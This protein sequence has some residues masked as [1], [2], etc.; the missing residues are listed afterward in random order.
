MGM[1]WEFT[2][3]QLTAYLLVFCRMAGIVLFNPL[4]ARRNIPTQFSM[5]LCMGLALLV[6][7]GMT[8]AMGPMDQPLSLVLAVG[9]ELLIGLVWGLVFQIFYYL[10]FM[11]G[12]AIDLG[13]GLSM[14]KVFDRNTNIQMSLSGNLFNLMFVLFLFATNSHIVLIRLAASSYDIIGLGGA[15]MGPKLS[16]FMVELFINTVNL[17]IRL[18]MPFLAATFTVEITIGI[19][20]KLV[21][22]INIFSIHFQAKVI[23]GLILLFVFTVPVANFM[24]SY[25]QTMFIQM[26]NVLGTMM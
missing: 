8:D 4:L 20:M 2:Y 21:P 9:A 16:A 14:A 24:D 19:L 18:T 15:V 26:Q 10:L 25:I 3:R 1:V 22:Q 11:A 5:A 12:D 13:L 17:A 23:M 6:A 7:P